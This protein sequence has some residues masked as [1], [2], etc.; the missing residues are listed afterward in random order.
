MSLPVPSA[1]SAQMLLMLWLGFLFVVVV[2]YGLVRWWHARTNKQ[3]RPPVH[4]REK[5]RR[6]RRRTKR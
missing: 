5:A 2:G 6:R 3:A 4:S 1:Y